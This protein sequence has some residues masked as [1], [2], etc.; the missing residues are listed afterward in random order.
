LNYKCVRRRWP[1]SRNGLR[2]SACAHTL[3]LAHKS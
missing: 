1:N 2:R 3:S